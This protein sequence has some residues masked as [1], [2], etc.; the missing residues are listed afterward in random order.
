MAVSALVLLLASAACVSRAGAMGNARAASLKI[1][2]PASMARGSVLT[3]AAS[4]YSGKYNAISWSSPRGSA[5]CGAPT[6]DTITTQA[7]PKG[8]T[9]NVK[10][11]N[12]EGAPGPLTV[13]VYLFTPEGSQAK[14]HY[15][16]K[17]R[18]VTVT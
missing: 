12:I 3:V 18:R 2:A 1:S 13:C 7:V 11:T 14:G 17:S 16:V 5:T 8:H 15:V 10:L 6:S 4:G 9:F